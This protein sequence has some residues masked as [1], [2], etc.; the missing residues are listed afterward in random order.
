MSTVLSVLRAG[1]PHYFITGGVMSLGDFVAQKFIE[2]KE[3]FDIKRNARFAALGMVFVAPV[4]RVWFHFLDLKIGNIGRIAPLKKV[5]IDQALMAPSINT[6]ILILL[7]VMQMTPFDDIKAKMKKHLPDILKNQYKLWPAVQLF[8]F[9][10]VPLEY[11]V[12]VVIFVA[13][14]WNIYLANTLSADTAKIAIKAE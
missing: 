3:D 7:E 8:N 1:I 4:L 12:L 10:L 6:G 5:I 13:F 9:Y 11:R 14:F 2:K